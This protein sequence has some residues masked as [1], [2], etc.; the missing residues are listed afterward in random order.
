MKTA[1]VILLFVVACQAYY[2]SSYG[3]YGYGYGYNR[4]NSYNR[5]RHFN[6][7]NRYNNYYGYN[8]YAQPSP[9]YYRRQYQFSPTSAFNF[10][11]LPSTL[12]NQSTSP[13]FSDL[14][15][16]F[17]NTN[18]VNQGV[19]EFLQNPVKG[20][21]YFIDKVDCR[22]TCNLCDLCNTP[23]ADQ[24]ICA[25]TEK[26]CNNQYWQNTHQCTNICENG[27]RQCKKFVDSNGNYAVV[28]TVPA[29]LGD[30][31]GITDALF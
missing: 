25:S 24:A 23:D 5:Y 10:N 12:P 17:G 26:L 15:Q 28:N 11:S 31:T 7:Y 14:I 1:I 27:Q 4:Y 2:R 20:C 9:S 21:Q 22:E 30:G 29:V 6:D 8:R 16:T 3:R 13:N 19:N 18:D